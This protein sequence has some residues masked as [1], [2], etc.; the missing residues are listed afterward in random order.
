MRNVED[1]LLIPNRLNDA[2]NEWRK[3]I[4]KTS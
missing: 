3:F 2:H 1:L 4:D